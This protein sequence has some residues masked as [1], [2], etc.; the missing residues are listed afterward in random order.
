MHSHIQFGLQVYGGTS[1]SNLERILVAQKKAIRIM[2]KLKYN[3]SCREKFKEIKFFTVFSLY[4]F[5]VIK[6]A[7]ANSSVLKKHNDV[8]SHNTRNKDKFTIESHRTELFAKLPEQIGKKL[9]NSL[10]ELIR[11]EHNINVFS[12]KLKALL[13]NHPLYSVQEFFSIT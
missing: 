9:L 7:K 6:Y 8:H 12:N 1:H 13:I 2:L 4:V 11:K 5:Q 10:P 3:E